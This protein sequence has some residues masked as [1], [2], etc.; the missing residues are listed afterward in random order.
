[1]AEQKITDKYK[2][3]PAYLE[4]IDKLRA[5]VGPETF[6]MIL[7]GVQEVDIPFDQNRFGELMEICLEEKPGDRIPYDDAEEIV[8]FFCKPFAGKFLKQAKFTLDGISSIL[9][10]LDPKVIQT[11]MGS[12]TSLNPKDTST[13]ASSLQTETSN[14]GSD[15][16]N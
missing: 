13:D 7:N 16:I 6:E 15:I 10:N 8:S 9:Q 11:L 12:G 4:R 14:K 5:F 3:S 1:M 2:I